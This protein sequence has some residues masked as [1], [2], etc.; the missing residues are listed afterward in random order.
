MKFFKHTYLRYFLLLIL[1]FKAVSYIVENTA[2]CL[3]DEISY[4]LDL[5]DFE[6]DG[7]EEKE[8]E[9]KLKKTLAFSPLFNFSI[10]KIPSQKLFSCHENYQIQFLEF[11]TPPPEKA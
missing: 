6:K 10:S 5:N 1:A 2:L 8:V 9:E 11:T 3:S 7:D 4:T